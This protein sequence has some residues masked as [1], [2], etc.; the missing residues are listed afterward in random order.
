[1]YAAYETLAEPMKRRIAGL[2]AVHDLDYSRT[3]A[4]EAPMT[5]AQRR[6]APPV[7]HPLVRTHPQTGRKSLYISHHVSRVEGL[8]EDEGRA[9]FDELMA[10]AIEPR[11]VF[12]YRWR[13]GDVV[14]W[15][16]RCTMHC[17]TPYDA[18]DERRVMHRTVVKGDVPV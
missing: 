15:D 12:P 17:A 18:T 11:F 8:P 10:H 6:E 9:L 5:E 2:R 3:R 4:G 1:M 7:D 16:N 14:I 13:Q